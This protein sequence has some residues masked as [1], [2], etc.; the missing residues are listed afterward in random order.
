MFQNS[1][2]ATLSDCDIAIAKSNEEK[3]SYDYRKSQLLKQIENL[4]STEDVSSLI[5]EVQNEITQLDTALALLA[6]GDLKD[7]LQIRKNACASKLIQLNNRSTDPKV[8]LQ[9][10]KHLELVSVEAGLAESISAIAAYQTRRSDLVAA[11]AAA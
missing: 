3:L 11:G 5:T 4:S 10:E 9:V 8:G 1:N 7:T 6:E 2:L